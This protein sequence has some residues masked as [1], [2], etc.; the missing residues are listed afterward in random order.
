MVP[1]REA[2]HYTAFMT[3]TKTR[4]TCRLN[5]KTLQ[6]GNSD[7][8]GSDPLEDIPCLSLCNRSTELCLNSIHE[9]ILN[10]ITALVSDINLVMDKLQRNNA[11]L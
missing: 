2:L 5:L 3:A 11:T 1:G 8:N 4:Q 7:G 6:A 9:R 10:M